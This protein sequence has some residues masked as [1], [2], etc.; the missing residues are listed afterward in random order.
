MSDD[1]TK[2]ARFDSPAV[3]RICVEGQIS[4]TWSDRLEGL[5]ITVEVSS[6][7]PTVT[8]L[9]GELKDQAALTGVLNSLY[10]L[11]L[12]VLSVERLRC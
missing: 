9:E 7:K 6:N 4:P 5:S 2:F 1:S 8:T 3:Y 11:L 12:P 10:D